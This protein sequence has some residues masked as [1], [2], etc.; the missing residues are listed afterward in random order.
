MK[1]HIEQGLE[2]SCTELLCPLRVDSGHV[3][4][5]ALWCVHQPG[6]SPEI[7]VPQI[8]IGVSLLRHDWLNHWSHDWIQS[9]APFLPGDQVD[10]TWIKALTLK[11]HASSLHHDPTLHE[12]SPYQNLRCCPG[13]HQLEKRH[14]YHLENSKS[15]EFL[16]Q[17][18]RT[19]TKFLIME[20][21]IFLIGFKSP[22]KSCTMHCT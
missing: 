9:P 1:R 8:F 7:W 16:S 12:W 17:K 20:K 2:E 22:P 6:S 13:A 10:N 5:W 3:I 18:P 14:F 21:Q 15:F 11:S 4:L 19:K